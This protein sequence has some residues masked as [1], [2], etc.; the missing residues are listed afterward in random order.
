MNGSDTSA[1]HPPYREKCEKMGFDELRAFIVNSLR[2]LSDSSSNTHLP[3]SK[4]EFLTLW[5]MLREKY[6]AELTSPKPDKLTAKR[7]RRERLLD[8]VDALRNTPS[9]K[10]KK[11]GQEIR[12]SEK[13]IEKL[14][15]EI[16]EMEDSGKYS[17]AYLPRDRRGD[18]R[19]RTLWQTRVDITRAFEPSDNIPTTRL[20]WRLAAS[21]EGSAVNVPRLGGDSERQ[22]RLVG[23]DQDRVDNVKSLRPNH[24]Y[25]DIDGFDG[26]YVFKFANTPKA[27]MECYIRGRALYVIK[28]ELGERWQTMS[29]QELRTHPQ[30]TW[31]PHRGNWPER[32]KQELGLT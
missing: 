19:R 31:I 21:G 17:H 4:E 9:K 29:K 18:L 10:R 14:D 30:V 11:K 1:E 20:A 16:S 8:H 2:E 28:P 15:R 3:R 12:E 25:E 23:F 13:K 22:E 24:R 32:V 26:Y 6:D 27:L 5:E 7:D